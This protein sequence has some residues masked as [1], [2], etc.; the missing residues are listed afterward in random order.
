MST[1]TSTSTSTSLTPAELLPPPPQ[2]VA[3]GPTPVQ[4]SDMDSSQF[5]TL[6]SIIGGKRK[7]SRTRHSKNRRS[8]HRNSKRRNHTKRR[9][10]HRRHLNSRRNRSR[11]R[12][13]RRYRGGQPL[14]VPMAP[15]PYPET[16]VPSTQDIS[17]QLAET[18]AQNNAN[19]S[20]DKVGPAK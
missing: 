11:R 14:V 5:K 7:K 4:R 9:T 20:M 17:K 15:S 8:R 18:V 1:S 19:S 10:S 6:L 12:S 3:G 16:A 13:H 2:T